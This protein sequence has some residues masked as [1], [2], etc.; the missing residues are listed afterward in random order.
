M[1]FLRFITANILRKKMRLF[2][3]IGSFAVALFLFGLLMTIHNGFY[4]GIEAAG[5]DRLIVRN[6]ISIIM[7]LPYSY[8]A[9][10]S[11][12]EGVQ[13]VIPQVWFGGYY[14]DRKNFFAQFAVEPDG[15]RETFP[16]YVI[17]DEQWNVF[18][19]DRQG[20]IVG[21]ELAQRYGWKLGDRIPLQGT[22]FPG[23][24]EFNVT[25]IY[26]GRREQDDETQFFFHYKL[27]EERVDFVKGSVGWYTVKVADPG[28][29]DTILEK[30]DT[31]FANS[32]AETKSEPEKL[33]AVGFV[34]QMGNIQLVLI[35]VGGVVIF[36]LL[37]VT[38]STMAMSVRERT[39]E[40]AVLKTLGF[41]DSLVLL[42]VMGESLTFAIIGG[43]LGLLA[44]KGFTLLGDPTQG[45]LPSFFLSHNNI[46]YGVM[47]TFITGA[48]AG[49]IPAVNAMQ[50][51]IVNAFRRV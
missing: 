4:Q 26:E 20:C 47:L 15:F 12:I 39:G 8:K 16:D 44:A 23:T 33:F 14:Q 46:A 3:T 34:K 43:A 30:I 49:I 17:S 37:L 27:I 41:T 29:S 40:I 13:Q 45:M 42:L 35:A 6:K 31:L 5:A 28:Q 18:T 38:G 22:I 48:L 21:R 7:F 10:M 51:R 50:L 2:L 1:K 24:W 19:N 9:K 25:A 32:P 36:T 11:A